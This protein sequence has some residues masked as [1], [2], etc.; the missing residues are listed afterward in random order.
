M[1]NKKYYMLDNNKKTNIHKKKILIISNTA[2]MIVQFNMHNLRILKD[3]GYEVEVACNF[4]EGNTCT[5]KIIDE[6]KQILSH[7]NIIFHQID[8][9]RDIFCFKKHIKA[10]KK[11]KKII[12][13]GSFDIIHCHTPIGGVLARLVG[14]KF[15][16]QGIIIIYTAHGFHFFKGAPL[17]NWLLFYPVEWLCSWWTDILI[18]INKEDYQIAKKHLHAKKVKYIPGVGID[19]EKF[20]NHSIDR[21]KKREELCV[22]PDDIMILSVGE[23][24]VRKNHE[25]V[26]KALKQLN[27][28]RVQYFIA[29]KGMLETELKGLVRELQLND[30]VHFLGFRT[31]ISELCQAADLFVFPSYQEGLPV[32]LMEAIACKTPVVCSRIRGNTDLVKGKKDLF[33]PDNL[34]ELVVCLNDLLRN[35][36]PISLKENMQ[37]SVEANYKNLEKY[38]LLNVADEMKELFSKVGGG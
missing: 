35:K 28:S 31:D 34:S 11:L 13:R 37:C 21:T 23:L 16:K 27:H 1:R 12:E 38:N 24:I 3:L 33:G 19:T 29:G 25:I 26:I 10:Y 14:R 36:T 18:T 22:R 7:M 5:T 6:L 9:E 15:R 32:A 8:F 17:K 2:S 20:S 30:Q 4:L